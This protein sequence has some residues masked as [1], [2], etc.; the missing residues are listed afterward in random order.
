MQHNFLGVVFLDWALLF[1]LQQFCI[2]Q[3]VF[4][5]CTLQMV[6]KISFPQVFCMFSRVFDANIMKN[7]AKK[8]IF[9]LI[10]KRWLTKNLV[11][12]P[13]KL[14]K[15]LKSQ[16]VVKKNLNFYFLN[17]FQFNGCQT[18]ILCKLPWEISPKMHF[19]ASFCVIF[20]SKSCKH[21]QKIQKGDF[22]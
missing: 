15:K 19:F 13:R 3:L 5:Y 18:I 2:F 9:W 21:I 10:P 1:G 11:Q 12:Q 8:P 22:Y 6:G 14:V 7:E 20:A 4:G 16:K 17:H